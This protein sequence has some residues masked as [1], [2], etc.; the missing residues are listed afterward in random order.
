M[1][2]VRS[3]SQRAGSAV[4]WAGGAP[5]ELARYEDGFPRHFTVN[6]TTP[7]LLAQRARPLTRMGDWKR[8]MAGK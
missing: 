3:T 6:A 4:A 1:R 5:R 7:W 2:H 8:A